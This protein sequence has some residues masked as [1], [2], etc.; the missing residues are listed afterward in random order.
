[1]LEKLRDRPLEQAINRDASLLA[2]LDQTVDRR[3]AT[4]SQPIGHRR[5]T[6]SQRL[7]KLSL[8]DALPLKVKPQRF[9]ARWN[10]GQSYALSIGRTYSLARKNRGMQ[11]K[12]R[13]SVL[14][15]VM[16]A[17]Q[18]SSRADKTQN[19]IARICNISQP[20]VSDWRTSD[21]TLEN[22][23]AL[24]LALNVCVEWLYTERGPKRPG[25]PDP[26]AE[27]L[28]S[29]WQG[30]SDVDRDAVLA[31]ATGRRDKS[32]ESDPTDATDRHAV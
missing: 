22:A 13:R 10:I 1:M 25:P 32:N 11:K 6:D 12:S 23:K 9:H 14:S 8:R 24:A 27:Q 5:L 21:P 19:E 7:R 31:Y 20:S 16:E 29:L 3:F 4:P 28:W 17:L 2:D 26:V 18:E 15:R 30:L